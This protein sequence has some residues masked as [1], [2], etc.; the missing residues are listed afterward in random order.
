V[1]DAGVGYAPV[2]SVIPSQSVANRSARPDS[3][4]AYLGI[5]LVLAA[6]VGWGFWPSY[7]GPLLHGGVSRPWIVHV[8]AAVFLGWI[9]LLVVQASLVSTGRIS[10][11]RRLG[12]VGIVYGSVVFC[13]G[14]IV[15]IAAPV[16]RVRAHQITVE[17]A[18]L[19]VMYNLTDMLVFVALFTAAMVQR[20]RPEWH[21]RL[22]L[23]ATVGLSS[24]AVG[25]V[26]PGASAS[27]LFVR[28]FPLLAS[29]AVDLAMQRRV[30]A[31]SWL[32]VLLFLAVSFKVSLYSL[33]PVWQ[34]I[35]R[36]FLIPFV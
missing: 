7:F 14:L 16:L 23:S 24:A 22:I 31:V 32:S 3:R 17:H 12:R 1:L 28:L 34:Q 9:G 35:G 27:Y 25:R 5:V 36:L 26:L 4:R 15:S 18:S 19:V 30:Y 29:M 8:H 21:K 11:H 20:H 33:S 10:A 2:A 13:V 6:T